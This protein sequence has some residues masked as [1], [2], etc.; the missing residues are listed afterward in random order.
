MGALLILSRRPFNS[1]GTIAENAQGR[2]VVDLTTLRKGDRLENQS[3]D[4]GLYW[5][6]WLFRYVV[7]AHEEL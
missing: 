3:Y 5:E 6:R 4:M 7:P 1:V 2:A